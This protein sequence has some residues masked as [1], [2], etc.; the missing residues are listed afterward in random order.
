M[1]ADPAKMQAAHD[2]HAAYAWNDAPGRTQAEVVAA[3][4]RAV[5]MA[6]AA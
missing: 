1:I 6:R 2:L 4:A 3:A 5:E